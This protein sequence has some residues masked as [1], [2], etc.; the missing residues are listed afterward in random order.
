METALVP[1]PSNDP[2]AQEYEEAEQCAGG[3]EKY[4]L[5]RSSITIQ[6]EGR[7]G[8]EKTH[9]RTRMSETSMWNFK[10]LLSMEQGS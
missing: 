10:L 8:R 5:F 3:V 4:E 7:G 6:Y 9:P 2:P 1:F